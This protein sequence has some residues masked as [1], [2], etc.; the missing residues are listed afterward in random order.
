MSIA[1]TAVTFTR[2]A[3][4]TFTL[5]DPI[6]GLTVSCTK[7]NLTQ[8]IQALYRQ[9]PPR[10]SPRWSAADRRAAIIERR[11]ARNGH[12]RRY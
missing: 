6:T 2:N 11:M 12:D 10:Q 8:T 7:P 9:R 3:D 4:G 5:T 1:H